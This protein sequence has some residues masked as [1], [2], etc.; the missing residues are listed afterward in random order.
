[1]VDI[2][3]AQHVCS[4]N[5]IFLCHF[6]YVESLTTPDASFYALKASFD[7]VRSNAITIV[8]QKMFPK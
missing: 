2:L 7:H 4:N 1:M 3:F 8:I 6:I 5:R